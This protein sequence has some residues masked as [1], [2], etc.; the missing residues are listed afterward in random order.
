MVLLASGH[1][2]TGVSGLVLLELPLNLGL[3]H[4]HLVTDIIAQRRQAARVL[5]SIYENMITS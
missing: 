4:V 2:T 3:Y 5:D 1:V